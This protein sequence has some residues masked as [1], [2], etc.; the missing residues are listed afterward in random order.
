M[1]VLVRNQGFHPLPLVRD[2]NPLH[3][4]PPTLPIQTTI[5]N[6]FGKVVG[7]NFGAAA[8]VGDGA[9]NLVISDVGC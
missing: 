3:L 5:M 7:C 8:R 4:Y 6:G 9:R 1:A 2:L